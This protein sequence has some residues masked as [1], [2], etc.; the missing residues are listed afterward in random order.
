M[1]SLSNPSTLRFRM[2]AAAILSVVY[3]SVFAFIIYGTLNYPKA[4]LIFDLVYAF[5]YFMV[6]FE[7][8]RRIMQWVEGRLGHLK[9][10]YKKYLI[11]LVVFVLFS[12]LSVTLIAVLPFFLIFGDTI[13]AIEPQT[14]IRLNYIINA[15]FAITYYLFL[16]GYQALENFHNTRLQSEKLQKEVAQAQYEALKHQVNPHFLFNSLNVLSSL[17]HLDPDLSEKFIDQLAKAY[18]YV[19]EQ[20][21]QELVLLKTELDF[22]HSFVFL[23]KIRFE[24]K[25]R[26]NVRVPANKLRCYLPPLTLQLLL[27]NAVKHNALSVE[28]PLVVDIYTNEEGFLVVENNVQLR[29]QETVSTGVGIRNITSRYG[30]LTPHKPDFYQTGT[31]YVA[32]VPLLDKQHESSNL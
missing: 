1:E 10:L 22:I 15:L 28:S 6:L 20:K 7:G 32:R 24:E 13:G 16:T 26:V 12:L 17:V 8:Y 11:G 21:D 19:L 31:T 27:E 18:R 3:T 30:F 25:L 2:A 5:V 9:P 14:E 4:H 23:L 29:Q